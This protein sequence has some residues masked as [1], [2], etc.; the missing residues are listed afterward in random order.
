M[1]VRL[2][3]L[4]WQRREFVSP[5]LT[6]LWGGSSVRAGNTVRGTQGLPLSA[7]PPCISGSIPRAS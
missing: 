3:F 7:H 5:L 4:I 2:R 6:G 1:C